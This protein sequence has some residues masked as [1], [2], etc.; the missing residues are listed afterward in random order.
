MTSMTTESEPK[1]PRPTWF[2]VKRKLPF[3]LKFG[4]PDDA[5]A[6]AKLI[7]PNVSEEQQKYIIKLFLD[8]KRESGHS[9]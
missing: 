5:V 7:D 3:L 2:Q 1:Q 6:L 8:A 4:T 9:Q